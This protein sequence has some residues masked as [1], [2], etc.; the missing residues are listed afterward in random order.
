MVLN[1]AKPSIET[2]QI[3]LSKLGV[4]LSAQALQQIVD[5]VTIAITPAVVS[6]LEQ[7]IEHKVR[8]ELATE[9]TAEI[10]ARLQADWDAR[11]DQAVEAAL[12][13][14]VQELYEQIALARRRMFGRSSEAL[15][16]DQLRL[17]LFNEAEALLPGTTQAD[18]H[19]ELPPAQEADSD[20]ADS[21]PVDQQPAKRARGK[22]QAL[23][24]ELPRLDVIYDLPESERLCACGTP[25]V[26][27]GEE[28]SEQ[29][30]II[31]MQI[32]VLR[33]VRK[34]Y[35]CPDKT[36]APVT[37]PK[38]PQVLPK[39]N[40]S[41]RLLA[42]LMTL[43]YVD[44]LPLARAEH[45]FKR[46]GVTVPR[47]T[48]ARLIIQVAEKLQP[49]AN[50]ARD[51]ALESPFIHMDETP[52]QVLKEPGRAAQTQ[53]YMWVQT[54][55]PPGRKI[56]LFDYEASRE[57]EVPER[58]LAGY[59][60]Y[61]MTDGYRSYDRVGKK[62]GM[63]HLACWAHA[64]RGF[65]EAKSLQAK[66]K[67]GKADEM[68]NLIGQLYGVEKEYKDADVKDRFKARQS[69]SVPVL[70]AIRKWLDDNIQ[71]VLPSHKLGQAIAYTHTLW[72]R[73]VRYVEHGDLPIDNNPA[74]NAIRP[75][76]MGRK[77]WLFSDTQAGA[78]ASALIYS[79]V[80][81]AKGCGVEPY[82][83]LVYVLKR[84]P[85]AQTADDY[86]K[87]LPWNIHPEHLAIDFNS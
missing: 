32:R 59:S 22:R 28:V 50:L 25:M 85:L 66:G 74:E 18:D 4:S 79:L 24:P 26:E 53:S 87:L 64:R 16:T 55:G 11:F 5:A 44:G 82:C 30:D 41:P 13:A 77:A 52:V 17:G 49:I 46:S 76:V 19:I 21:K 60:G 14:R 69:E 15:G 78:R 65:V 86:E 45:V 3:D 43:K 68:L 27:I 38:P 67:T 31:P 63:T 12:A 37:A 81:T 56:V 58:L 2:P 20:Q 84:L 6:S 75:F 8:A 42:T 57:K 7:Q 80:E 10:N 35:A 70:A 1:V 61:L 33:H 9:V 51:Y 29:L 71:I 34:R 40:A 83:W 39:S 73:L 48:Q 62:D 72:A 23:P 36:Q 47:Q 54:A